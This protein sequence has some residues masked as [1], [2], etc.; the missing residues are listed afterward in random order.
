M[1][2]EEQAPYEIVFYEDEDGNEPALKFMQS[3]DGAKRRAIGVAINE[4]L[5]YEGPDVAAGN[6][7]RS[8]GDGL[9]EFKLDQ[10]AEQILRRKGRNPRPEAEEAK[11]LLRMFFHPYG[12]KILLLLGGYDKGEQSSKPRQQM[13]IEAAKKTLNRWKLK[14]KQASSPAG[15]RK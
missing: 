3:L 6:F 11:I 7:G 10:D 13:E 2:E 1:A 15:K 9:Y 12:R 4:V 14:Q 5:R 8:L